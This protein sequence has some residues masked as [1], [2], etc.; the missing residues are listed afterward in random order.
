MLLPAEYHQMAGR[1]GRPQ[2]D[3]EG[4]ALTLGALKRSYRSSARRSEI[5]RR[6][7]SRSTRRRSRRSTISGR[8]RRHGHSQRRNVG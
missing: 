7:A 5:K 3:K 8:S 2:F 1:A 4:I 6:R